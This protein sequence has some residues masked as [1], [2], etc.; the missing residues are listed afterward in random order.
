MTTFDATVGAEVTQ[1]S[2]DFNGVGNNTII[3]GTLGQQIKVLQLFF[4]VNAA[5]NLKFLSNATELTGVMD[6]QTNGSMFM[7]YIQLPLTCNP[8][9]SFIINASSGVQVSGTIWYTQ[10]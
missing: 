4:V 10:G 5:V 1:A 7:D 6:F 8:G 9:D 2:L 3:S